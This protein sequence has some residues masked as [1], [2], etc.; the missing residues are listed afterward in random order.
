MGLFGFFMINKKKTIYALATP[1]GKSALATF[2]I[3]GPDAL[4]GISGVSSNMPSKS[5]K[6]TVNKITNKKGELVDKTVT[7]FFCA[8]NS[9]TGEDM[10]EISVH[11]GAAIIEETTKVLSELKGFR[12]A[13]AGEFT[14]RSFENNK[15]DLTQVEA[16]ADIINS[17]TETQRK[18]ALSQLEG[19]ITSEVGLIS[20]KISKLLA[21]IEATI[22]FSDEDLPLNL[23]K[24]IKEQNKNIIRNIEKIIK[25]SV[26]NEKIR[27]GFIVSVVGKTNTGKST[28]INKISNREVSIVTNEPGTTRDLIEVFMDIK[29]V[30][31]RFFDTA[32]LR[33]SKNKVEKI[34]IKKAENLMETADI[35]LV[36]LNNYSEKKKYTAIKNK[37]FVLSKFD[38]RKKKTKKN[39]V[40]EISSVTGYGIKDLFEEICLGLKK[41]KLGE[42][43]SVSR[44]RHKQCLL[45]A[46]NFLNKAL[47]DKNYDLLAEDI[48]SSLREVSKIS[49][50]VDVESILEI[51]FNDFCIGK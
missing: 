11:G 16:V 7:T 15:L 20:K 27:N 25:E 5:K 38:K 17:E 10:I 26:F 42:I 34:G 18:L 47:I 39:N 29:G 45:E 51:I 21:D 33:K 12:L 8:P 36:F 28:F 50:K 9:Y 14:R 1:T 4:K 41:N 3:S 35:N 46:K 13:E 24:T 49:G 40:Y 22:D 2:R 19:S 31:I 48:R 6:I 37:I 32:G 44:E 23:N 43:T 30:P